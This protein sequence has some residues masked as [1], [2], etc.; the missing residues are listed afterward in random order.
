MLTDPNQ[1][2]PL[3]KK[4]NL[5]AA[6]RCLYFIPP[7][8]KKAYIF[9]WRHQVTG[10]G[11][12][13]EK[14]KVGQLCGITFYSIGQSVNFLALISWIFP[15]NFVFPAEI[16]IQKALSAARQAREWKHFTLAFERS[17]GF[18]RLLRRVPYTCKFGTL[19]WFQ[20][21]LTRTFLILDW[22]ILILII[23]SFNQCNIQCMH[24]NHHNTNTR[25]RPALDLLLYCHYFYYYCT[26]H[27]LTYLLTCHWVT[28]RLITLTNQWN[29]SLN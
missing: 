20:N 22:I 17:S 21:N 27:L 24:H 12:V 5:S 23:I 18:A 11:N 10:N 14:I 6:L 29:I 15:T 16:A 1:L 13:F 4:Y 2:S 8:A 25:P 3:N 9:I 26:T 7:I 19:T 28:Q